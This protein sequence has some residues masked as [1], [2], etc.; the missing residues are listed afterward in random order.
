MFRSELW[1]RIQRYPA[2]GFRAGVPDKLV[3]EIKVKIIAL[4][5]KSDYVNGKGNAVNCG[6][7]VVGRRGEVCRTG[8]LTST[9]DLTI[10]RKPVPNVH[11]ELISLRMFSFF[12]LTGGREC[13]GP[14]AR[15]TAISQVQYTI[16]NDRSPGAGPT[17]L[18]GRK[19]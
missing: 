17:H 1:I 10:Q 19:V 4:P 13:S 5:K 12:G 9:P 2:G 14:A 7:R 6:K 11:L 16:M 15:N 3:S 8:V 18:D